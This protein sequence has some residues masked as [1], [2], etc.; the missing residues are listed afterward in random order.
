MN[1]KYPLKAWLLLILLSLIWGSSFILIKKA[2]VGLTPWEVGSLRIF[3]AFVV[4]FP[5]AVQ[6]I[7]TVPKEKIKWLIAVGFS[8]TFL[9]AFLFSVAQTQVNSGITG[10][11]NAL[12][13]IST[14]VIG[15]LFFG[16]LISRQTMIG[17][18]LGF[19]GAIGLLLAGSNG[20][21]AKI[22]LYALLIVLATMFYALNANLVK[23]KLNG[24]KPLVIAS[25]SMVVIGIFA[26]I[27]LVFFTEIVDKMY[28]GGYWVY[29]SFI[30][31]LGII[32][33]AIALIIFNKIVELTNPV[34]TTSVTYLIPLVAIVWGLIDGEELNF[35]HGLGILTILVGVYIA[36]SSRVKKKAED[37]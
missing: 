33:T 18:I 25:C 22:N 35:Y 24:L 3:F 34:F 1:Q 19:L 31:T 28:D 17:V 15:F 21:L 36:N 5:F 27:H 23:Y 37:R 32:G 12:V 20:S 30:A 7:K 13:P 9:P 4:L 2:L 26:T 16:Q 8:S 6:K 10:V 29:I 11:L 14:V